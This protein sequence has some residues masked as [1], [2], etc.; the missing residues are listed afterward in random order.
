M[1]AMSPG[2]NLAVGG[3]QAV[4]KGVKVLLHDDRGR[5]APRRTHSVAHEEHAVS[6]AHVVQVDVHVKRARPEEHHASRV[7]TISWVRPPL[8]WVCTASENPAARS[9]ATSSSRG[10]R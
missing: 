6:A 4:E 9:L 7:P 2:R 5:A 3:L 8:S 1:G 10:G